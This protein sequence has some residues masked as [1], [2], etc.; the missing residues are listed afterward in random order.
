MWQT[1]GFLHEFSRKRKLC[2]HTAKRHNHNNTM[3]IGPQPTPLQ[4]AKA[5]ENASE[6]PSIAPVDIRL[7]GRKK[8]RGN[9]SP[10]SY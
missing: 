3:A 9:K 7:G 1:L 5:M 2:H 4:R 8:N 10:V 6:F